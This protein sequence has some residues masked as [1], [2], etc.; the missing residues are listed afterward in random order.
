MFQGGKHL[1]VGR[2]RQHKE[3]K[4]ESQQS[5]VEQV[6]V[7]HGK[8]LNLLLKDFRKEEINS[9]VILRD[10][11][12]STTIS[13]RVVTGSLNRREGGRLDEVSTGGR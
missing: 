10:D 4:T 7:S 6:S 13:S 3:K 11:S 2:G 12:V 8:V 9:F 5:E 1:Q